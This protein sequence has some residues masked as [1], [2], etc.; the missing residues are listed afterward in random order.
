MRVAILLTG[1]YRTFDSIKHN[2]NDIIKRYD[3]D[4]YVATWNYSDAR[5]GKGI[6]TTVITRDNFSNITNLKDCTIIDINNYNINRISFVP[7]GRW[8]DVMITN[9]RAI[10]HGEYWANRL[11]DQWYIVNEGFKSIR[12]EYDVILRNRLDIELTNIKLYE[13]DKLILPNHDSGAWDFVDHLAFGNQSIMKKYCT[14]Y[15]H[16][17]AVYDI[18][19]VDPTHGEYFLKFYM[20]HY[21]E[22]V[23]H[24]NDGNISYKI[25]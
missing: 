24:I 21:N 3:A 17:Q 22:P 15:E 11:K 20:H 23:E 8:G 7:N 13:S 6:Q 9:Q 18:H 5:I 25:I 4:V 12:G 19:N 10:E 16:M 2:I 1:F 14:F